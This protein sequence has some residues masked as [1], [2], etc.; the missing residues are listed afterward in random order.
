VG[1][2]LEN[3]QTQLN[4]FTKESEEMEKKIM[5]EVKEI[6]ETFKLLI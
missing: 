2:K 5:E 3:L 6:K 4:E 1:K